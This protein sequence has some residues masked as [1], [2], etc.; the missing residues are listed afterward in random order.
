M[1]VIGA[2]LLSAAAL[3]SY[4]TA[5]Y[6]RV[7]NS[8]G[9]MVLAMVCSLV[10]VGLG[11]LGFTEVQ[12]AARNFVMSLRFSD[13]L[14]VG[15]LGYLLFANALQISLD[16]IL[17]KKLEVALFAT[18]S[19]LISTVVVGVLSYGAL[20]LLELHASWAYCFLFG[21]LISPTDPVAVF[22]L[23]QSVGAP[24]SLR[25]NISGESLF[26]DGV[27][28]VLFLLLSGAAAGGG[29]SF[30]NFSLLFLLE[31]V[32]GALF[33]F[34]MGYVAYL[35]L[36]SIDER[37]TELLITIAMVTGGY[38]VAR[39]VG[40]SGAIAVVVAGLV[41]GNRGRFFSVSAATQRNLRGFWDLADDLLN[42]LLFVAI[43]LEILQINISLEYVLA[44]AIAVVIVLLAR[45]VSV[46]FPIYGLQSIGAEFGKGAVRVMTWGG[47]R[48]GIP[49]ALALAAPAGQAHDLIVTM[50][51]VVVA[52][53]IIVQGSTIHWLVERLYGT[54]Q[55]RPYTLPEAGQTMQ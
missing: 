29:F 45:V 17:S 47:L 2:V 22:A 39:A 53:S 9:I 23:L 11:H 40:I 37:E 25:I 44:G 32:G 12:D 28:V 43:G 27:G 10:L 34:G 52:F 36:T 48:G 18:V 46:A 30:A 26:N 20:V 21:A 19:V 33:G 35:F 1:L 16:E 15:L 5:R 54:P 42:A 8:V 3:F 6:T 14:L 7:P 50:T 51:Y 41:L 55:A 24:R 13:A 38:A 49:V 4:L 31:T